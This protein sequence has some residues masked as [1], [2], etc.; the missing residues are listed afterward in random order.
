LRQG[1]GR[2][3]RA[4]FLFSTQTIDYI[5]SGR[6]LNAYRGLQR[7]L[8]KR[9]GAWH[10]WWTGF[11]F[12]NAIVPA[13]AQA[14]T[15]KA[16]LKWFDAEKGFGFVVLDSDKSD[17]FI[18]LTIL[19]NAGIDTLGPG[20]RLLCRIKRNER[21]PYVAQII[22]VLNSGTRPG[23]IEKSRVAGTV[24]WYNFE[25]QYGF[26]VADDGGQD[27][28]VTRKHLTQLGLEA[29]VVG[30]RVI[31]TVLP[32]RDNTR[33]AVDLEITRHALSEGEQYQRVNK[34][35]AA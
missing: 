14:P 11:L 24:K 25:K 8:A 17:V 32:G 19:R 16:T 29:L 2:E 27:I 5:T 15:V 10:L 26:I 13:W 4:A 21:G 9:H 20:A 7:K 34:K 33:Q 12:M 18:H 35:A 23:S 28:Y 22:S 30:T 6:T 31:A 1:A 3:A